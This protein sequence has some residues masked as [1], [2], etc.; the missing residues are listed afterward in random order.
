MMHLGCI[1]FLCRAVPLALPM[2]WGR[3]PFFVWPGDVV[4]VQH[5]YTVVEGT[6]DSRYRQWP[7]GPP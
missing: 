3:V 7:P 5:L 4:R 2:W 1:I 6:P